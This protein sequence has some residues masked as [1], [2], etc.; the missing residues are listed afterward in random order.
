[1]FSDFG[2]D[3]CCN[4]RCKTQCDFENSSIVK[5]I[6]NEMELVSHADTGMIDEEVG[7]VSKRT[8]HMPRDL[9]MEVSPLFLYFIIA[10]FVKHHVMC[11]EDLCRLHACAGDDLQWNHHRMLLDALWTH[12]D[13]KKMF[14]FYAFQQRQWSY[15]DH[16]SHYIRKLFQESSML[17][18]GSIGSV[19]AQLSQFPF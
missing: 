10:L 2:S 6:K 1:M 12:T 4:T 7:T 5:L 15:M 16:W 8:V 13:M 19:R 9:A 11:M 3:F 14:Q 17:C 18:D